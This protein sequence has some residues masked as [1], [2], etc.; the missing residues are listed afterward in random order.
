[1]P[2]YVMNVTDSTFSPYYC[3]GE[4]F[5]KVYVPKFPESISFV[6]FVGV[7]FGVFFLFFVGERGGV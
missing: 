7:F 6:E 4:P 5:L 2:K 3:H 1:M